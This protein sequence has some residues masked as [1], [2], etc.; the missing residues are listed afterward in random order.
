MV[1]ETSNKS[2]EQ[3]KKLEQFLSEKSKEGIAKILAFG[4]KYKKEWEDLKNKF[5]ETHNWDDYRYLRENFV[6]LIA[7]YQESEQ[8]F[9]NW[10]N[11][12]EKE[13]INGLKW[14][15]GKKFFDEF[16][17]DRILYSWNTEKFYDKNVVNYSDTNLFFRD[18]EKLAKEYEDKLQP[19]MEIYFSDANLSLIWLKIIVEKWRWKLKPWMYINFY[20]NDLWDEWI[21]ILAEAWKDSLQPWFRL[22]LGRNQIW[23]KW[24][25]VLSQERKDK[26]QI[27]MDL[28][29]SDN[30]FWLDWFDK[31]L[32]LWKDSLQPWITLDFGW[33]QLW[34]EWAELL[35][36]E[37]KDRLQPWMLL[38]LRSTWIWDEWAKA[39]ARNMKLKDWVELD[40]T[41]N[42][43]IHYEWKKAL[44]E[45]VERHRA[46]WINCRILV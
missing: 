17:H 22:D 33:N 30:G 41:S 39:I 26:L 25:E 28:S 7:Q 24:I 38:N 20:K 13:I 12:E 10:L 40:L 21:K 23:N 4:E 2:I 45:C 11:K 1:N 9:I 44:Q 16:L 8:K 35:A 31:L 32:K 46:K 5:W 14:T 43:A 34:D 42:V 27:W 36:D 29:L 6:K 3:I 15:N 37:R 18:V 19:W